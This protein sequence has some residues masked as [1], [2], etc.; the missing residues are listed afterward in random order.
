MFIPNSPSPP[1]GIAVNVCVCLL[2]S[3]SFPTPKSYH[4]THPPSG[5]PT[6]HPLN[7]LVR[8]P[9]YTPRTLFSLSGIQL[10]SSPSFWLE[11]GENRASE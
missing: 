8:I 2:N 3:L 11:P 10:V 6:A 4:T 9:C 5:G 7:N 1:S